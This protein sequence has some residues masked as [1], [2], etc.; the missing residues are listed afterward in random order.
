M[1]AQIREPGHMIGFKKACPGSGHIHT[2]TLLV[3]REATADPESPAHTNFTGKLVD[4]HV[5]N[6]FQGDLLTPRI[7][8]VIVVGVS[9]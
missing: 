9:M 1:H 5:E 6:I 3:A 4:E 2:K 7:G 8:R